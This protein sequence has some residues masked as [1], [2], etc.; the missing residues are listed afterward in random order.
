M[1]AYRQT[2]RGLWWVWI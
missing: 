1:K 2:R